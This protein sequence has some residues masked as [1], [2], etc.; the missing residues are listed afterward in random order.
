MHA[1]KR[2]AL[3]SCN[4]EE[5]WPS[6]AKLTCGFDGCFA[7]LNGVYALRGTYGTVERMNDRHYNDV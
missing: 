4:I 6:L 3:D 7:E 1:E 5:G 2:Y